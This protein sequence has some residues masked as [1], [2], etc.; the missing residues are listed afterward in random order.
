[1]EERAKHKL[2]AILRA[3]VKEYS[4]L[5]GE[6]ELSTVRTLEAYRE[7]IMDVIRNYS[8][9]VV[10]SPG[11]N[12]LA[13]FT[14]V[15]DAMESAVEIRNKLRTEDAELPENRRMEFRIGIDFFIEPGKQEEIVIKSGICK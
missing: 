12:L 4:R 14:S 2:S 11:D 9:R 8:G 5:M 10:D 3:D 1:M 13:E 6:D 7:M 15:V